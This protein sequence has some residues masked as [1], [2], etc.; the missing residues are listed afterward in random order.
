MDAVRL[1]LDWDGVN[2]V[3]FSRV[4]FSPFCP[5]QNPVLAVLGIHFGCQQLAREQ[6]FYYS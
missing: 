1:K 3:Y 5:E 4:M 2:K 6:S